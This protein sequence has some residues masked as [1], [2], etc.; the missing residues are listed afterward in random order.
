VVSEVTVG[1]ELDE[2]DVRRA[3]TRHLGLVPGAAGVIWAQDGDEVVLWLDS[4]QVD[5]QTGLLSVGLDLETGQ[6][7][8]CRQ[9]VAITL[10]DASAPPSL[11]A[12]TADV[13]RG[14]SRIAARWGRVLQDATWGALLDL[15]GAAA[16]GVAA[17]AGRLVVH[18][19]GDP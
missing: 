10:P 19:R 8:R 4:L 12:L 17:E 14:E 15:A 13:T 6:S 18:H 11:L 3:L 16:D 7:G 2:D 5:V 9:E 1:A